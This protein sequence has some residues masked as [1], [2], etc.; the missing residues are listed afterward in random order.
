MSMMRTT[1]N[2][3]RDN[4]CDVTK[5]EGC[6]SCQSDC[7]CSEGEPYGGI[8]SSVPGFVYASN[9]DEG[10]N[11]RTPFCFCLRILSSRLFFMVWLFL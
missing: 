7:T 6:A 1:E 10:V 11:V 2:P 9:F 5:K 3:D 4:R 8:A